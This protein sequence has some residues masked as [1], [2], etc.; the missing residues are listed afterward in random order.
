M[1]GAPYYSDGDQVNKL[2]YRY[3]ISETS[4]YKRL[5][6][7]A[8]PAGR[9]TFRDPRNGAWVTDMV[10]IISPIALFK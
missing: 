6:L 1:E 3:L 4:S 2:A 9:K 5:L 7:P 10:D 8:S